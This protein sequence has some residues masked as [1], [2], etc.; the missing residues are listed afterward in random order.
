[1]IFKLKNRLRWYEIQW[2][3]NMVNYLWY[4]M[5]NLRSLKHHVIVE[6]R[7]SHNYGQCELRSHSTIIDGAK[8]RHVLE[9]IRINV[10]NETTHSTSTRKWR[11]LQATH[12]LNAGIRQPLQRVDMFQSST[13]E[14]I[15][16]VKWE[17][18]IT[19]QFSRTIFYN[20][21]LGISC[22]KQ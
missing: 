8:Y 18:L 13:N 12:L 9:R 10:I 6:C 2:R 3:T 4:K 14:Q 21:I 15:W 5:K 20:V 1:M 22:D 7:S 11:Q 19:R 17:D 16:T